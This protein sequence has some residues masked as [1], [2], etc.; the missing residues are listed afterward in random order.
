MSAKNL[1]KINDWIGQRGG[2]Q[3]KRAQPSFSVAR[4]FLFDSRKISKVYDCG[5]NEGQWLQDFRA[6]VSS[7]VKVVCFE[8]M[9][10]ACRKLKQEVRHDKAVQ[11]HQ[12]ALSNAAGSAQLFVASNSGMSSSL[13]CPKEHLLHYKSVRFDQTERVP[14][15]E[16]DSYLESG[17]RHYLKIDV[18]GSE[19]NLLE[20]ARRTLSATHVIEIELSLS[21]QMYSEEAGSGA[22]LKFL[23]GS[24]FVLF[25][26]S[27]IARNST[28]ACLYVD[29][30]LARR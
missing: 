22:L 13:K 8:P 30:L 4:R 23:E 11:I 14:V 15:M 20:G 29:A 7:D 19:M 24:G 5:S 10:R 17:Q 2:F 21:G 26:L 27:D 6:S 18:Q 25:S 9:S 28:G 16:L 1:T 3:L 12:V